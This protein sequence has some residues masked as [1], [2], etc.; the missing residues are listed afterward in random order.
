MSAV[1]NLESE[2]FDSGFPGSEAQVESKFCL[3]TSKHHAMGI[4][5]RLRGCCAIF[6]AAER[7]K[8]NLESRSKKIDRSRSI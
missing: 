8:Q 5:Q 7:S 2:L 3:Y 4:Q 6:S 1:Q